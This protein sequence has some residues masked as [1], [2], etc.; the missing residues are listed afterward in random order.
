[1]PLRHIKLYN[2]PGRVGFVQALAMPVASD[3]VPVADVVFW[4]NRVWVCEGLVDGEPSIGYREATVVVA[5]PEMEVAP[6][7]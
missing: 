5:T 2:D 1:M 6:G 4:G 7:A 3:A